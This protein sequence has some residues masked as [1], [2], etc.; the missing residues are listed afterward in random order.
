MRHDIFTYVYNH[1]NVPEQDLIN[2]NFKA[3]TEVKPVQK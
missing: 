1:E 3:E 2:N